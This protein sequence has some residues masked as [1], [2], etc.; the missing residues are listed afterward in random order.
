MNNI[1][2]PNSTIITSRL[3]IIGTNAFEQLGLTAEEIKIFITVKSR[4]DW[5]ER[6]QKLVPDY[7]ALEIDEEEL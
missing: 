6:M 4:A 5:P 2:L 3:A 1:N 7:Q